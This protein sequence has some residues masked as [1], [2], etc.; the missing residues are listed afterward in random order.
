MCCM[1]PWDRA[2]KVVIVMKATGPAPVLV[3]VPIMVLVPVPV[4][5]LEAML[6]S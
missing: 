1:S 3:P 4:L 5:I 2:T 6:F